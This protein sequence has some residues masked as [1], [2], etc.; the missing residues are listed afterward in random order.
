MHL[1]K[2]HVTMRL[3]N[4]DDKYITRL[5]DINAQDE[6]ISLRCQSCHRLWL[7]SGCKRAPCETAADTVL[8]SIWVA[9]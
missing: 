5:D 8:M 7:M 9:G 3:I 6:Y 1:A 2:L 4:S